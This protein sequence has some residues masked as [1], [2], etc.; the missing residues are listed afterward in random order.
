MKTFT[1]IREIGRGGFGIVDLVRDESG[2]EFARKT[3]QPSYTIEFNVY[4]KLRKRFSREVKIQTEIGGDEIIPILF[5]DLSGD[6]PWFIMPV[7]DKIYQAQINEDKSTGSVD[8]NAIAD[9]LNDLDYLH[10]LGFVHRDLNPRNILLHNKKWKLSDLG[11]VLPPSGKTVTLTADTAIITEQY[12]APEQRNDFHNSK[13]SADIY[14]FGCILHDIFGA[15]A[16]MP[17]AKQT[18]QGHIGQI[19]EKCTDNKPE[20]RPSI[21]ALRGLVLEI[22]VE[23]GGQCRVTDHASESWLIRLADID[24]WDDIEL[25][26]FGRFFVG[27]NVNEMAE[28]HAGSW[29]FSLSTPFLTKIPEAALGKLASKQDGN[30][31][32]IIEKYCDWAGG[33]NFLFHF[34]DTVCS[35]LCSIFDSGDKDCKGMAFVALINLAH[36]HNRFH[37]MRELLNRCNQNKTSAEIDK[38][39]SIEM[40]AADL[41][42]KFKSC[43]EAVKWDTGAIAECIRKCL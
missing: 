27:L 1:K 16:R 38:R 26:N 29:V 28:T 6:N 37:V 17:Y 14:S 5:S 24:K 11:A 21:K 42:D 23:M 18:A 33:T 34:A 35:R 22:L 19:I 2:S 36:S 40:R 13:S 12:C 25:E 31:A 41:G 15:G 30:S 9:I 32:A 4:D 20:K 10:T 43:I 7:A 8:I 3:F 39:L